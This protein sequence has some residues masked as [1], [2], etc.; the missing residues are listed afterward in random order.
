[1]TTHVVNTYA[2]L[3]TALSAASNGDRIVFGTSGTYTASGNLTITK[4]LE[5]AVGFGVTATLS[6]GT[7]HDFVISATSGILMQRWTGITIH[8]GKSTSD[9]AIV[10]IQCN[11]GDADITFDGCVFSGYNGSTRSR[12][13]AVR[14]ANAT[15]GKQARATLIRCTAKGISNNAFTTADITP[16]GGS[17][18]LNLVSEIDCEVYDCTEEASSGHSGSTMVTEGG[19]YYDCGE[20]PSSPGINQS[21]YVKR[22]TMIAGAAFGGASGQG[23]LL[24]GEGNIVEWLNVDFTHNAGAASN[25]SFRVSN[26]AGVAAVLRIIGSR[27]TINANVGLLNVLGPADILFDDCVIRMLGDWRAINSAA[28][29]MASNAIGATA[30]FRNCVIDARNAVASGTANRNPF[31]D[32]SRT[33]GSSKIIFDGTQLLMPPDA[34]WTGLAYGTLTTRTSDTAGVATLQVGHGLNV[35]NSVDVVWASGRRFSASVSGVSGAD[36]TFSGG[37]GPNLPAQGTAVSLGASS[38]CIIC[39]SGAWVDVMGSTLWGVGNGFIDG[40]H[41]IG[42]TPPGT[43]SDNVVSGFRRQIAYINRGSQAARVFH[44]NQS[45]PSVAYVSQTTSPT[46]Y[47]PP[48]Y[49]TL[50]A[51]GNCIGNPLFLTRGSD[52]RFSPGSPLVALR[53]SLLPEVERMAGAFATRPPIL[54]GGA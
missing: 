35:G 20:Y 53:R 19:R 14:C 5:F 23:G 38:Q 40:I 22:T 21:T 30:R 46:T 16:N 3:L 27:I 8:S 54:K 45:A 44:D 41:I 2:E 32:N 39:R 17:H 28:I 4:G 12:G 52:F 37:S 33:D 51:S 10:E 34:F 49:P 15:A 11:G 1:M 25:H 13:A 48:T 26:H 9:A 24:I 29:L 36:V 18:L 6:F 47:T 50:D 42:A 43:I 31:A 7:A